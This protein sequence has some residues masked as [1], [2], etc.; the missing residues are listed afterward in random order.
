[1]ANGRT[2][3]RDEKWASFN[4]VLGWPVKGMWPSNESENSKEIII[5]M[6]DRS[7]NPTKGGYKLLAKADDSG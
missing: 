2:I 1:M 7:N 4:C 5:N 6:V 3:L